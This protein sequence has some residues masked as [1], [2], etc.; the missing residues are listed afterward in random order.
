MKK[1]VL[2]FL[3]SIVTTGCGTTGQESKGD[4]QSGSQNGIVAGEV[5]PS[6]NEKSPLVYEYIVKNQTEEVITLEFTSSQ[7]FDYSVQTK[8]G[9]DVYLFSSVA[10][11]MQATGEEVLEQGGELV[12]EFD[13][14]EIGLEPGEYIV[15]SWMTTKEGKNYGISKEFVVE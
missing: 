15:K 3:L 7:R 9:K 10:S 2:L 1:V 11:F 13:L 12:Y 4:G 5:V 14:N 8:D 6:L